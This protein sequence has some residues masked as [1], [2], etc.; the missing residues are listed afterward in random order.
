MTNSNAFIGKI[1][2][3]TSEELAAALK[4]TYALWNQLVDS[5]SEQLNIT[6]REWQSL[7]PKYGWALI[8]K[9]KKRRIVYLS[10]FDGCFQASLILGDKAMVKARASNLAKPIVKILD[11]APHY[12]EGTGIRLL[13][14]TARDLPAIRKLAQIKLEN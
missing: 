13:V 5:L 1:A 4:S 12:P 6:D 9:V 10:P 14:K 2:Q 8:L 7:K 3:P 11:E